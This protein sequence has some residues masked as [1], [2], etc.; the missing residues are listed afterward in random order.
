MP[1]H[2]HGLP[3]AAL[4]DRGGQFPK[5][6]FVEL[7]TRLQRVFVDQVTGEQQWRAAGARRV[8]RLQSVDIGQVRQPR[9]YAHGAAAAVVV[10][11]SMSTAV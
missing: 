8:G 9:G 2:R 10:R 5:R 7:A 3:H 6:R 1:T 11:G 4:G